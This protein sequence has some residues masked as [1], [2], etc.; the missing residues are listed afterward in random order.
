MDPWSQPGDS[1]PP[2]RAF[3]CGSSKVRLPPPT[4]RSPKP[5]RS[6]GASPFLRHHRSVRRS[7][8]PAGFYSYIGTTGRLGKASANY[9]NWYFSLREVT[10][11]AWLL[12]TLSSVIWG[13]PYLFIK[14]AVDASVPPA[15]VAWGRIALGAA[16]LLPLVGRRR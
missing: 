6:S 10:P 1:G 12:F 2:E 13:V 4:G 8:Q 3:A 5:R 7:R 11:R 9:A 15:F 14:I 16:V